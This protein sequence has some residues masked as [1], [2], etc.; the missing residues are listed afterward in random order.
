MLVWGGE[1]VN[2]LMDSGGR[3][4]PAEDAWQ[5]MST[6]GSP[7]GRSEQSAVWTGAE[8]ILWGGHSGAA[9]RSD[10]RRYDPAHDAWTALSNTNAPTARSGHSAVW[11][12]REM[13]I[14]AG[15]A[16]VTPPT[17][18]TFSLTPGGRVMYLYQRP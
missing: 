2:Q 18:Q 15:S 7:G 16:G 9:F 10:G 3:Y 8:L 6:T 4:D 11:T 14:F 1:A 17:N 12:G 13:L 5:P